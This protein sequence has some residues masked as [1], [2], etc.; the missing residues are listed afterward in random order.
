MRRLLVRPGAIGD[1]LTCFPAMEYLRTD[2]TEVWIP[3]ALVSIVQFADRVRALPDTGLDLLGV[4]E[5]DP[6]GQP[7][8]NARELRF[9]RKLVRIEPAGV[10]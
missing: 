6:P 4:V 1:C 8:E 3:S 10:S 2:Y 5:S 7:H 9:N